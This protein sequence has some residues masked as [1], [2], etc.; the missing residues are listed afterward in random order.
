M[1]VGGDDEHHHEHHARQH[2]FDDAARTA[3]RVDD[4]EIVGIAG[5]GER[6]EAG[7]FLGFGF[8]HAFVFSWSSFAQRTSE[9]IGPRDNVVLTSTCWSESNGPFGWP[10]MSIV[11]PACS[12]SAASLAAL[13][14]AGA[15]GGCIGMRSRGASGSSPRSTTMLEKSWFSALVSAWS[16]SVA[17]LPEKMPR[18][19]HRGPSTPTMRVTT[20]RPP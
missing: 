16:G 1:Q 8:S 3:D 7:S 6:A 17:A 11:L 15:T 2:R 13:R 18:S 20:L 19:I 12:A 14:S 9:N 10:G 4:G 5:V